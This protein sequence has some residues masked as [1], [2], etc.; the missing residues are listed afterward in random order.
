MPCEVGDDSQRRKDVAEGYGGVQGR[1]TPIMQKRLESYD[2]VK[3][4]KKQI[5][6]P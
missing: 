1:K 2:G 3:A 6:Y 5:I 4:L